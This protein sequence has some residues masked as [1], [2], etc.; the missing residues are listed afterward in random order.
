MGLMT[1]SERT[2]GDKINDLIE[3]ACNPHCHADEGS[4]PRENLYWV[5]NWRHHYFIQITNAVD[6][7]GMIYRNWMEFPDLYEDLVSDKWR[8]YAERERLESW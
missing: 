1:S 4:I 3:S 6:M 5:A 2:I 8:E 7:D